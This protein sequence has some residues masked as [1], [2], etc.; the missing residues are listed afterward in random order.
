M[1]ERD[2]L[3][4]RAIALLREPVDV[5]PNLERRVA[6]RLAPGANTTKRTVFAPFTGLVWTVVSTRAR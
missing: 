6:A 2:D 3:L 1:A 4:E 5:D